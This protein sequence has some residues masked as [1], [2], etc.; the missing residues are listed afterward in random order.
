MTGIK[1]DS[2]AE[3]NLTKSVFLQSHGANRQIFRYYQWHWECPLARDPLQLPAQQYGSPGNLGSFLGE[4]SLSLWD[5]QTVPECI[6]WC[7]CPLCL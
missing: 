2:E 3:S 7:P 4:S 6:T 1:P 5:V